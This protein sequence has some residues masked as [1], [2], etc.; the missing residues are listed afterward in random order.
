MKF[1]KIGREIV[2]MAKRDQKMR[3]SIKWRSGNGGIPDTN[4][5]IPNTKRMQ[6]IVNEIGWPTISKVGKKASNCAWLLVQHADLNVPFQKRCLRLL[7][8]AGGREVSRANIAYL[9]DRVRVNE[10]RK[11]L[12]GTQYYMNKQKT[13]YI[14][15][16]IENPGTVESRR[17]RAGFGPLEKDLKAVNKMW[18][19][20][21]R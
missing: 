13:A 16:P 17:K 4:V 1:R 9:E 10:N 15:R 12:Y 5:D 2:E 19:S 18:A 7:K 3:R 11:Q 21:F 8:R 20:D 6:E 14:P